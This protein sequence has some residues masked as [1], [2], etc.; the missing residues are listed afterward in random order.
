MKEGP[1]R[2]LVTY[3]NVTNNEQLNPADIPVILPVGGLGTRAIEITKDLIPK[4]LIHLDRGLTILDLVCMKLQEV[5][6]RN[7]LFCVAH[8]SEQ[9]IT[10][11]S[12]KRWITHQGETKFE[13]AY[14]PKPLGAD[15]AIYHAVKSRNFINP[16]LVMPGD[17]FLPWWSF[18]DMNAYHVISGSDITIGVTSVVSERTTDVGNIIVDSETNKIVKTL[19]RGDNTNDIPQGGVRLTS[20]G[21]FVLNPRIY[22][23]IYEGF[24]TENGISEGTQVRMRD[25]L[26]PWMDAKGIYSIRGYDLKGEVL[27]LGT[28]DN[29]LYGLQNWQRYTK[30]RRLYT[31]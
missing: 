8:H 28:P 1:T 12:R 2:Q 31:E 5:G 7:F 29:I 20:A 15:G 11:L 21:M 3:E 10:H 30:K 9:I 26:L 27:D 23:Q 4:H 19:K 25:D 17:M 22:M 24:S 13:F 18:G 14:D 16:V 6:F